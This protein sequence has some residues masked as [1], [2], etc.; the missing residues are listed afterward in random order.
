MALR[1]VAEACIGCGGC[2]TACP[3]GAITQAVMIP[4][5]YV[6]DAIA[7]NDCRS[8]VPVCPVDALVPDPTW[9][10]CHG[11]GCPLSSRRYAAW[12][13]TEGARRC[14]TCASMLWLAPDDDAWVCPRCRDE[15]N[16]PGA[17]CPKVRK[18]QS[19]SQLQVQPT[20]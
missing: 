16:G 1:I 11:R 2:E 8:C 12:E 9:A 6:I 14:P 10:V 15:G 7:C 20:A 18:A 13:C 4:G 3:T 17:S 19:H 5:T